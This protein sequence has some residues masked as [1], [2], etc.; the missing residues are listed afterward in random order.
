MNETV[1]DGVGEGWVA[2]GLVPVFDRQLA[3]DDGRGAAMAIFEDFQ[4]VTP[5]WRGED[6]KAPIVNDQDLHA[7]DGFE[8]AFMAAP[9]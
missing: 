5:L 1:E 8:N 9:I 3:C 7:G 4:K 6:C 2:D